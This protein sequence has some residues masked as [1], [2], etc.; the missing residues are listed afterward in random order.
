MW[1]IGHFFTAFGKV[2]ASVMHVGQN[3][4][5]FS[6]SALSLPRFSAAL[7]LSRNLITVVFYCESARFWCHLLLPLT[8]RQG[9]HDNMH[10][11]ENSSSSVYHKRAFLFWCD[12]CRERLKCR[13]TLKHSHIYRFSVVTRKCFKESDHHKFFVKLAVMCIIVI[14]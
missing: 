6:H 5:S 13:L 2:V 12:T 14:Q 4:I 8:S 10:G 3:R 1:L 11:N 7:F 9:E